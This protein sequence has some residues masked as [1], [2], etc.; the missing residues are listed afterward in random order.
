MRNSIVFSNVMNNWCSKH[1]R[2]I[3]LPTLIIHDQV[4]FEKRLVM[5]IK[6]ITIMKGLTSNM[7]A[8]GGHS[9]WTFCPGGLGEHRYC[10]FPQ[11]WRES[12]TL[13]LHLHI[14]A[15]S[16]SSVDNG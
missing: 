8:L 13:S 2:T 12:W 7:D 10:P 3:M 1:K 5:L 9:P 16:Q 15:A 4:P 6:K 11:R 14:P